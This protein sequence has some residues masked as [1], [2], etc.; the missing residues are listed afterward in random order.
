MLGAD[1]LPQLVKEVGWDPQCS[2]FSSLF[3][4]SGQDLEVTALAA[5]GIWQSGRGGTEALRGK[6]KDRAEHCGSSAGP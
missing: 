2:L 1:V 5:A 4:V 3:S 6:E